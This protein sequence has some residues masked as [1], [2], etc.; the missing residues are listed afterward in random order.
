MKTFKTFLAEYRNIKDK[1]VAKWLIHKHYDRFL[2]N[3]GAHMTLRDME[4]SM[5]EE[6]LTTAEHK[7][8]Q[9]AM[10]AMWKDGKHLPKTGMGRKG[11]A[12]RKYQK[13]DS[14]DYFD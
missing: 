8:I 11:K 2:K 10:D 9:K 7:S 14:F 4:N 12:L 3:K 6:K 1:K 13:Q 5:G